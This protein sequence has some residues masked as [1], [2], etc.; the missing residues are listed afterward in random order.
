MKQNAAYPDRK[1]KLEHTLK[2]AQKWIEVEK[3]AR[4]ERGEEFITDT[5]AFINSFQLTVQKAVDQIDN[6]FLYMEENQAISRNK[7]FRFAHLR[8]PLTTRHQ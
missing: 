6:T 5:P 4:Q 7:G 1:L 2:L 8:K 3:S